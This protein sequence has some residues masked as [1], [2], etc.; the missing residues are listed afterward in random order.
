M[1]VSYGEGKRKLRKDVQ[2]RSV[3]TTQGYPIAVVSYI[4]MTTEQ[5]SQQRHS[6]DLLSDEGENKSGRTQPN[7]TPEYIVG[8]TDG[9]GC[10]YVQ[11]RESD[12]Y[13]AGATVH[14][15]FHIKRRTKHCLN[16][17]EMQLVAEKYTFRMITAAI[18]LIV[19]GILSVHT[20]I[21]LELSFRFL[22][23]IRRK[24]LPNEKVLRRFLRLLNV[25]KT[26]SILQ[27]QELQKFAN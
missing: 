6:T 7:L 1:L 2:K 19:T 25:L 8:L 10:F 9:E 11:I 24:Q 22:E 5:G 21:Y 14:L 26:K 27:S 13:S 16:Q 18:T 17:Y 23:S 20:A 15:H 3:Y 12:R 4:Y